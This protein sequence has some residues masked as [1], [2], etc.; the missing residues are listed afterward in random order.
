MYIEEIY[1]SE[2]VICTFKAYFL[3]V[4]TGVYPAFTK[5]MWDKLLAQTELTINPVCQATLNPLIFLWKCFN[6]VFDNAAT[7]LVPIEYKIIIH[8]TSNNLKSCD[9]RGHEG[10]SEGPALHHY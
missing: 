2:R 3:S 5:F 10:F 4:L 7:A 8:A 6:C 9:Q 1:I